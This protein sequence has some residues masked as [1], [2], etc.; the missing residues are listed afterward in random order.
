MIAGAHRGI[1]FLPKSGHKETFSA[2]EQKEQAESSIKGSVLSRR[3]ESERP[4]CFVGILRYIYSFCSLLNS[5][6]RFLPE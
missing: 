3:G 2:A 5:M 1:I 6:K 4:T